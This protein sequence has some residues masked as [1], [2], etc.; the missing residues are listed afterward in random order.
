MF[1]AS[2]LLGGLKDVRFL[3]GSPVRGWSP[4]VN[5]QRQIVVWGG[6]GGG[7]IQRRTRP[8]ASSSSPPTLVRPTAGLP[9][10]TPPGRGRSRHPPLSYPAAENRFAWPELIVRGLS[11]RGTRQRRLESGHP[12]M[13]HA[14]DHH[15]TSWPQRVRPPCRLCIADRDRRSTSWR[16]CC[17]RWGSGGSPRCAGLW[18]W[19]GWASASTSWIWAG[20]SDGLVRRPPVQCPAPCGLS[21]GRV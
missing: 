9:T 21:P 6:G 3:S 12:T 19:D 4:R 7:V 2:A 13:T 16:A 8:S 15:G 14:V 11:T 5:W 10:P 18:R 1:A 17:V 20:S